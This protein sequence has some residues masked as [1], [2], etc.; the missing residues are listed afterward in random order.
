MPPGLD[1]LK[2]IVILMMENRYFDHLWRV[3]KST[4]YGRILGL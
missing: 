1:N 3:Q 2:H 4:R